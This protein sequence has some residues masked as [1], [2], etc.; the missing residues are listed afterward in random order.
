MTGQA[1]DVSRVQ[2]R[3]SR[4]LYE[5]STSAGRGLDPADLVKLVAD[6]AGDLLRADAVAVYLW[7]EP[8][9]LLMPAYTN[10]ARQ[11]LSDRPLDAGEGATGQAVLLGRTVVIDDYAHYQNAV[12]WA[13]AS[14][15]R[16]VEAVPLLVSGE[17]L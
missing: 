17:A 5:L 12:D 7:D 10:D 9:Q 4:T 13:V 6:H 16:S 2:A 11:P 1:D 8:S 14:G 3:L 15:V